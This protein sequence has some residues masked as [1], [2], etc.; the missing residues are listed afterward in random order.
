MHRICTFYGTDFGAV[1]QM[2]TARS[3]TGATA[4]RKRRGTRAKKIRKFPQWPVKT[5][6]VRPAGRLCPVPLVAGQG[7]SMSGRPPVSQAWPVNIQGR[8]RFCV[9]PSTS[10]LAC[11]ADHHRPKAHGRSKP[12]AGRLCPWPVKV[13][14]CPCPCPAVL[15]MTGHLT[16][17]HLTHGLAKCRSKMQNLQHR[18][19]AAGHPRNY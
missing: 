14:P 4:P 7:M 1:L 8:S 6:S 18:V 19:F 16:S 3:I 10:V 13:W 17:G 2:G 15:V 12:M 9:R 5:M 11:P